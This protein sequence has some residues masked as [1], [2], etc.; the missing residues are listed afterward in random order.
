LGDQKRSVLL[1]VTREAELR[2]ASL[3]TRA[4]I[5]AGLT[6]V[7]LLSRLAFAAVFDSSVRRLLSVGGAVVPIV[8]PVSHI[9]ASVPPS[10]TQAL[11]SKLLNLPGVSLL[12]GLRGWARLRAQ[13]R[14]MRSVLSNAAPAAIFVFDERTP[15]INMPLLREAKD[16]GL[17]TIVVPYAMAAGEARE[18]VR[19]REPACHIKGLKLAIALRLFPSHIRKSKN[20]VHLLFYPFWE[21]VAAYLHGFGRCSPWI[22]GGGLADLLAVFGEHD[23]EAAVREGV[24]PAK[25]RVTGQ[26]SLDELYKASLMRKSIREEIE[27]LYGLAPGKRILV[28]AVPHQAEE[29]LLDKDTHELQIRALFSVLARQKARLMAHVLLSLHPKSKQEHYRE[30]ANEAGLVLVK[31]PLAKILPL[32]EVMIGTLSSTVRWAAGL[33]IPVVV[34]DT[35]RRGYTIF[36]HLAAVRTVY[37][38]DELDNVLTEIFSDD[39]CWIGPVELLRGQSQSVAPIDGRACE[40]LLALV[41]EDGKGDM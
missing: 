15:D 31:E 30:L 32:A 12:R 26:P 1:A 11:K 5:E 39:G 34:I 22:L 4:A 23:R 9:A 28:C 6:P 29:N 40:R 3:L 13:R 25:I 17:R 16:R 24:L 8:E 19:L 10:Q 33:R 41:D 2:E 14:A 7:V 38:S 37:S 35:L 21:S 36:N 18:F 27:A 20:D